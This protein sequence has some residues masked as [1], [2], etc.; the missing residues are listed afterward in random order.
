MTTYIRYA[1]MV[2]AA[3]TALS[4]ARQAEEIDYNEIEQQALDA[5]ISANAPQA[6]PLGDEGM[7]YEVLEESSGESGSVNVR[8]RWVDVD[9]TIRT[10]NGD[11]VYT[12]NESTAR[13]LGTRLSYTHYVPARLYIASQESLSDI[14]AG[15]YRSITSMPAGAVWRVYIPSRL[16]FASSGINPGSG[17]GGQT[18]LDPDSPIILDSLRITD[19]IDNPQQ[20]CRDAVRELATAPA[21]D[22]WGK[23]A[24]DTVRYG[25]YMEIFNRAAGQT[26][27]TIPTNQSAE[28]YYKLRYL[29]GKLITS[30]VDSVLINNF[31]SVRSSDPTT[32]VSIT[33][34][35]QGTTP[36]NALQMPAKVFYAI[37]SDLCY[38]DI[39]RIAVPSEYAYYTQY[40]YPDLSAS[41][42]NRTTTFDFDFTFQYGDYTIE[43]RDYF[44]GSGSYYMPTSSQSSVPIGEIPAY[45]PLIYEFTV[46]RPS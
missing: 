19:I 25:M 38:G 39:G 11:V 40:M 7:Y 27:D 45:T 32:E 5:W 3:T 42:W 18:G 22:G 33:R 1:A 12:R 20:A 43:D 21:P 17:Y 28:I 6:M 4:C 2:L 13:M 15:I 16:A 23:L 29:D 46:R 41:M 35:Q 14:P 8:G 34:T 37:I 10:L 31:G 30:N 44:F 24:A 26:G 9:Y 36:T